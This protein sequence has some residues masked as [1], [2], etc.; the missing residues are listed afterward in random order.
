MGLQQLTKR[1]YVRSSPDELFANIHKRQA[2][3]I[4]LLKNHIPVSDFRYGAQADTRVGISGTYRKG[5]DALI[6]LQLQKIMP[7]GV[8]FKT[9][10]IRAE[11][12]FEIDNNA[13][14]RVLSRKEGFVNAARGVWKRIK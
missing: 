12:D 13:L 3:T 8:S 14:C 11:F 2:D 10:E 9:A 7:L 6:E 5:I 4:P 1:K